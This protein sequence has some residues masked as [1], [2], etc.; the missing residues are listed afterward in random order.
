MDPEEDEEIEEGDNTG[1]DTDS[2]HSVGGDMAMPAPDM[3]NGHGPA[4]THSASS[5]D[6]ADVAESDEDDGEVD[7]DDL[8]D[9]EEPTVE[10]V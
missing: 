7:D 8:E 4:S 5:A 2:I 3:H 9:E 6:E 10:V 1:S